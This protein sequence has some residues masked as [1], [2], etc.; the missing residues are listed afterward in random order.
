MSCSS[1]QSLFESDKR[2]W[3]AWK[4][5]HDKTSRS[6]SEADEMQRLSRVGGDSSKVVTEHIANCPECNKDTDV[7]DS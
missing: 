5:L 1:H 7:T 4:S 2:I 3:E 6:A